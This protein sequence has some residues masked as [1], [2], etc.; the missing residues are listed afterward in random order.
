GKH[1]LKFNFENPLFLNAYS[2]SLTLFF[3]L[4]FC[5]LISDLNKFKIVFAVLYGGLILLTVFNFYFSKSDLCEP[6]DDFKELLSKNVK[7]KNKSIVTGHFFTEKNKM[8]FAMYGTFFNQDD[9]EELKNAMRKIK[10]SGSGNFYFTWYNTVPSKQL[11]QYIRHYFPLI[12]KTEK[13]KDGG[14]MVFSD[15]GD[16]YGFEKVYDFNDSLTAKKTWLFFKVDSNAVQKIKGE[17]V[18]ELSPEQL[19][20]PVFYYDAAVL[21][22]GKTK[23]LLFSCQIMSRDNGDEIFYMGI[24]RNGKEINAKGFPA[25]SYVL[26][27][28]EWNY[29]SFRAEPFCEVRKGD[30]VLILIRSLHNKNCLVKDLKVETLTE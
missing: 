11:I 30:K 15:R 24:H 29:V 9:P 28:N 25:Y 12:E 20:V 2:I 5:F 1:E 19:N 10:S 18:Y 27:E 26:S 23:A 22:S 17:T 13:V 3:G 16:D 7:E 14:L 6:A 4:L 21:Y 8:Q